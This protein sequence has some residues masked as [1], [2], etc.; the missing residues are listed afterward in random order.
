MSDVINP[1]FP[2]VPP[3]IDTTRILRLWQFAES[4]SIQPAIQGQ[5]F[6]AMIDAFNAWPEPKRA[7]WADGGSLDELY[8]AAGYVFP[9]SS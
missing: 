5:I 9:R 3:E 4:R 7:A 6:D 8:R 2:I 1:A